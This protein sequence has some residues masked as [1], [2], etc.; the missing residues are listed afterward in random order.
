MSLPL[1]QY[2]EEIKVR[3]RVSR[4]HY[5]IRAE[6]WW[7]PNPEKD[8]SIGLEEKMFRDNNNK[9]MTDLYT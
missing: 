4:G 5:K 8:I 2:L 7:V 1:A 9:R 3:D 6:I